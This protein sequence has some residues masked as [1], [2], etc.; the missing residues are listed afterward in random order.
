M[1]CVP[2]L[3]TICL[4]FLHPKDRKSSLT[5]GE[6]FWMMGCG[7]RMIEL[8]RVL[9]G[10]LLAV[11]VCVTPVLAAWSA[12]GQQV[13]SASIS[14]KVAVAS[15]ESSASNLSG[16]TIKLTSSAPGA[17]PQTA[18]T[19]GE[20]HYEF[21]HL[22]A[23]TYTLEVD[24]DGF[25]P[26]STSIVV[27]A[28]Q[29]AVAD[30]PLQ[31][32]VIEEKVEVTGEATEIATQSVSA[33]ATVTE[34]QLETLPLRTGKFTEALSESPNVIRTQEGRLNFNGQAE[35]QG[36]LLV[37]GA[38]NVDPVSGSFA[39][40]IPVD[41]IQ[42][43]QV[44]STPDSAAFGGFSGGLTR[45]EIRPP[46][47]T[48]NYKIV[49]FI[50]SFR[51]K[52]DHLVGLANMTPRVEFGGPLIKN[53]LNFAE[54][55]TYEWRRDPIHGLSWPFNETYV[56][57]FL[58]FTEL[59]YTVS[60]KHLFNANLN[61]FP[62]TNLYSNI[63]T[64]I[65][66][67]ASENF[68][69]RG[70]SA[71]FSD[72]Y[73]FDSGMVLN[74]VV[75]YTNFYSNAHGQGTQEMTISP[76]GYG[77]NFF[78]EWWRNANQMEALPTLQLPAKSWLGSHEIKFGADVL[79]REYNSSNLSQTIELQ[80]QQFNPTETIGFSGRGKLHEEDTEVSAFA[81]DQW[82]LTKSLSVNFGARLST[83]TTG[84]D[85]AFAPRVGVAYSLPDGK[86]VL[87]G[88]VGMIQGHV[89]LLG[90]DFG[91]NQTR[92]IT[93]NSGPQAGKSFT[94]Q[95]VYLITGSNLTGADA[96]SNSP[97]TLTWNFEAESQL[98]KNVS[99][100]LSYYETH[101]TNLFVVNPILSSGL[102]ALENAGT[103]NYRQ[104]QASVR[105]RPS[106]RAELNISYAWSQARGDLNSLSDTFIQFQAPV[107]R[108]NAYGI[109]PSDIPQRVLAWGFLHIPWD[110]VVSPVA[111]MHSG[112]PYS[113]LD[114][115]QNYVGL[116]NSLRFP[117]YF[118]LDAKVYRDFIIRIPFLDRSRG[119]KIRLGVFSLDVTNRQNPHDVFNNTGLPASLSSPPGSLPPFYGQFAGF[120]R[121]F[122]GLAIGLGE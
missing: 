59:Q 115:F 42:S 27:A 68:Q 2:A 45:I 64:L 50:P 70:V 29:A 32:S 96:P 102:M 72:A 46:A 118:T 81:E 78:N 22:G 55:L 14:G 57:S 37:D 121:R 63:D 101:T 67:S 21:A 17:V 74:S 119:R 20:G 80:D 66:Q 82:N 111:D 40:P 76:Y 105:Y 13:A 25:K 73:Q 120:Q 43:I 94:L 122:T 18:Q 89:P 58:S 39:I 104:A 9:A 44:F 41:A 114:V 84:R 110:I 116:P 28:A 56:F 31:I 113:N 71:G 23:A 7:N 92:T 16:I 93:F 107:I 12:A 85:I 24:V 33:T 26:Y 48:W 117:V 49:D 51:A 97:R 5:L 106:E 47:P 65:P 34:Q 15:T 103:S 4:Y 36:M 98:R 11:L 10:L 61:I 87:R 88:G 35:S 86:T 30:V 99:V 77:G 60:P 54:D 3:V 53:K 100:R 52:N 8:R 1:V 95:N 69:R 79:Y 108:A 109:Q 62:S 19:N 112:F 6:C 90:A 75:R 91:D 83:Q 38:E